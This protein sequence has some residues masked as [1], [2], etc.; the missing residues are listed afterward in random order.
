M[1]HELALQPVDRVA[2]RLVGAAL[3]HGCVLTRDDQK[4]VVVVERL[5]SEHAQPVQAFRAEPR[6]SIDLNLH[7]VE[8]TVEVPVGMT[9]SDDRIEVSGSF[10]ILQSQHGIEPFSVFGGALSVADRLSVAFRL[11]GTRVDAIR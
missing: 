5:L 2:C 11:R 7:G 1:T 8:R 6:V 3:R 10:E 9:V 4:L